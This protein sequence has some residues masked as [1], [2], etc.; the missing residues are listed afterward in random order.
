M[1]RILFPLAALMLATNAFGWGTDGHKIVA[2]I[3]EDQLTSSAKTKIKALLPN[4]SLADVANWADS[5][6]G[7]PQWVHTKPW[8]FVDIPD[9][10]D[11][12]TIEHNHEG[13]VVTAITENVA[14]LKDARAADVEKQ[15]A[16]K[17]IVH[18]VGD[19]HQPLHAGRPDDVGGNKI[20]VVFRGKN[21]NLHSLWDS[22][23]IQE[24]K[25]DYQSYARSLQTM[26]FLNPSYDIPEFPFSVV[27]RE[28]MSARKDIYNFKAVAQD[29]APVQIPDAYMQRNLATMNQRLLWGG[30][31]LATLLNSIFK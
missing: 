26:S 16:L 18:F 10:E 6:K 12:G 2:Q 25:M 24:Q 14:I 30:K 29:E 27:I 8:H 23:M 1:K 31:R 4:Q 20:K 7:D 11:Y 17:F 22:G 15:E 9:G 13:D 5:I 21:L 19:L 3:A 28:D